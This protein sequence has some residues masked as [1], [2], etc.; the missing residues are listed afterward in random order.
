LI[1][2]LNAAFGT[3]GGTL[4]ASDV[5]LLYGRAGRPRM[6]HRYAALGAGVAEINGTGGVE[7]R[8]AL[9]L[10]AGAS[11]RLLPFLGVAAQL[12]GDINTAQSFAGFTLGVQLGRLR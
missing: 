3:G 10:E 8:L 12:F 9:L 2:F 6:L 7:Y 5:G 11:L 1:G 4:A